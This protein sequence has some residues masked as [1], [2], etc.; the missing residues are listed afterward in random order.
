MK[1]TRL[2]LMLIFVVSALLL[3]YLPKPAPASAS[4]L[5]QVPLNKPVL[6]QEFRQPSADWSAGHRGV[7]YLVT[8]DQLV[9]APHEGT[10][11]FSGKVV[12]RQLLSIKHP[13]G[14]ITSLEPVCSPKQKGTAV[15]TGEVIGTICSGDNYV[16]HCLPRLCLHFSLRTENGYLSP[17]MVL[18]GLSPSRLKPWD[19]QTCSLPS[20]AQC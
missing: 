11:S 3:S 18:G 13:N 8:T 5:W 15:K 20:G 10:V 1:P 2:T 4:I 9:F 16:S 14:M 12:D 6:V 7:D 19:G 17:L